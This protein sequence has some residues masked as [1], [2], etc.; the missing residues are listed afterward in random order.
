[1]KAY[2]DF[3][4]IVSL[5][6]GEITLDNLKQIDNNIRDF[7]F[8][9]SH[10]QEIDN[11]S[12]TDLNTRDEYINQHLETIKTT[13]NNLYFYLKMNNEV[14]LINEPPSEVLKTIREVP[15]AK[16]TMQSFVNLT[17]ANQKEEVRNNLD[18]KINEV[19][20]YSPKDVIDYF[21]AILEKSNC[22]FLDL[23][24]NSIKLNVNGDTFGLSERFAVAYEMLDLFGYW[25]DKQTDT[26]NYARLWDSNH[27]FFA[28]HCNYFISN[29]HRN[30]SKARVVYYLYNIGTKVIDSQGQL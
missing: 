18:I 11:I 3:N 1:M 16:A 15:F 12:H 28:A 19:N 2:L 10:I 9:A 20:N 4:I 13:S 5:R 17:N 14:Q 24:E 30:R 21:D 7:P 23:I 6:K 27:A 25:K 26:S 22:T 8:S 29:D